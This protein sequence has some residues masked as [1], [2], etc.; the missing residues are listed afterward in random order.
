MTICTTLD[1]HNNYGSRALQQCKYIH[2]VAM[3]LTIHTICY[4]HV[5]VLSKGCKATVL[6][7]SVITW[8]SPLAEKV[9]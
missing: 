4:V 9:Y 5:H 7:A 6:F 2:V 8:N 1:F 3:Y